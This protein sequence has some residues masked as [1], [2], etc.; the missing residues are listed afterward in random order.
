MIQDLNKKEISL[1]PALIDTSD[2]LHEMY[3]ILGC[4]TV[5]C[6]SIEINDKYYDIWCDDEA[7]LQANPI[8]T[9][10]VDE[11]LMIFG[12]LLFATSSEEGETRGLTAL[13]MAILM[14]YI[15]KQDAKLTAWVEAINKEVGD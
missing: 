7:L 5:D 2:T 11:D 4:N 15:K 13:D 3:R 12:N 9:L 6:V 14:S 8:P 1:K 10:Y